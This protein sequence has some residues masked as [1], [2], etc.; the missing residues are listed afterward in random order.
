MLSKGD[1]QEAI[2]KSLGKP[3]QNGTASS[4]TS[5]PTMS[6][7]EIERNARSPSNGNGVW[8]VVTNDRSILDHLFQLYF[9]W[10][11]PV[12]TFFH[13]GQFVHSYHNGSEG[14]EVYCS[15][16]LVNAVCAMA[17]HL[18]YTLESDITDFRDLAVDFAN[19]ARDVMSTDNI[20][21]TTIQAFAVMSLVEI[22]RGN[23]LLAASYLDIAATG[24]PRV[25]PD[26]RNNAPDVWR[27]TILGVQALNV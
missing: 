13:E 16:I 6:F 3:T 12:H 19:A 17:C 11:H 25:D 24:L 2:V 4:A 21:L 8:T 1:S 14:D 10:V 15:A 26:I 18:H 9:A 22:T 23:T 5:S 7:S 20:T 27:S